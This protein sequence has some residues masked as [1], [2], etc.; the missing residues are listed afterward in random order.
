MNSSYGVFLAHYLATNAFPG[1]TPLEF[2][3][4]GCLSISM[5]QTVS[6]LATICTRKY[7]TWATM[8]VGIALQAAGLF[9]ASWSIEIWQQFL[10]QGICFGQ[11]MGFLFVASVGL[12]L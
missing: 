4:I 9:G 10:S 2:A 6:P 12:V 3:F 1:V 7:G 5:C 8:S 11:G